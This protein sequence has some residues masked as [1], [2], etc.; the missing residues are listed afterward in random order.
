M[1]SFQN[2]GL[3]DPLAITT[4][5]VSVKEG[6]NPIG[7]F[8][9]GLKYAIAATLRLGGQIDI[10]RGEEQLEFR[11]KEQL[12]RGKLFNFIF[13]KQGTT[14]L[15]LAFTTEYGK[16]WE[17]WMVLRELRCNA[18]DEGGTA[19][20]GRATPREGFTTVHL[21]CPPVEDAWKNKDRYFLSSAPIHTLET[22]WHDGKISIELHPLH[23]DR[24]A[25][26]YRGLRAGTVDPMNLYTIN[27][28][29]QV[30]L[31]ED[32]TISSHYAY[33]KLGKV[34][35]QSM[36]EALI[37]KFMSAKEN[38]IEARL[39]VLWSAKPPTPT[40]TET[41]ARLAVSGRLTNPYAKDIA[42]RAMR[43]LPPALY[44]PTTWEMEEFQK[45]KALAAALGF[46]LDRYEIELVEKLSGGALG[47]AQEGRIF[48]SRRAF[49]DGTSSL[50]AT[51][52]EEFIHLDQGFADETR[53]MQDYLLRQMI[54]YGRLWLEKS[55]G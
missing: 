47:M 11:M 44:T 25:L 55:N 10:W 48:L 14:I 1:L 24:T 53:S 18:L 6:P 34:L 37:A 54:R 42:E 38:T 43:R 22:D 15:P 45:A 30:E 9:T 31:T 3:I 7:F 27:I 20:T 46:E 28:T 51:L 4:M 2:P 41:V 13:M 21:S 49:E 32:R 50:L 35:T 40:F 17:P 12:V 39:D 19:S 29:S 36:D 26:F 52:V 8:G 33:E 23:A 5:G 16:T